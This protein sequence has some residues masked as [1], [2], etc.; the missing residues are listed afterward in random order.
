M[1]FSALP[2]VTLFHRGRNS[3]L[4]QTGLGGNC[5]ILDVA[6]NDRDKIADSRH[7]RE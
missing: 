3:L 5:L 4:A 6:L 1:P 7:F 2:S